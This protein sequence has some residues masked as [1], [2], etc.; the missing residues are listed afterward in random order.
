MNT[1]L[2]SSLLV[3][4]SIT[5]VTLAVFTIFFHQTQSQNDEVLFQESFWTLL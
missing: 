5:A 1:K 4:T 3:I 2:V